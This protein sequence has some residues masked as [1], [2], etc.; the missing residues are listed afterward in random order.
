MYTLVASR[1]Y[2]ASPIVA[3]GLLHVHAYPYTG[4]SNWNML[5]VC[6]YLKET[7]FHLKGAQLQVL[8]IVEEQCVCAHACMHSKKDNTYV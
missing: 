6:T 4:Y 5:F 1:Q 2:S 7:I 8:L 3:S